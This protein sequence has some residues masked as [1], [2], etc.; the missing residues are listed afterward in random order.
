VV[1]TSVLHNVQNMSGIG[2]VISTALSLH[3]IHCSRRPVDMCTSWTCVH[4]LCCLS[5]GPY[6]DSAGDACDRSL[7]LTQANL[8]KRFSA[9]RYISQCNRVPSIWSSYQFQDA[10]VRAPCWFVASAM[11]EEIGR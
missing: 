8:A 11:D 7:V 1:S 10:V 9:F 5:V 3:N 2:V 4:T 6:D